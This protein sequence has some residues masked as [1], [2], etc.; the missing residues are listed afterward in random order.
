MKKN[1]FNQIISKQKKANIGFFVTGA[2][3]FYVF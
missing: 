2:K 1:Y 3:Y